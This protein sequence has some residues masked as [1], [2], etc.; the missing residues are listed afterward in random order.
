ME[1]QTARYSASQRIPRRFV[2][3]SLFT[4]IIG[5]CVT[6][7]ADPVSEMASFSVFDKVDLA[8]LASGGVKTAHGAPMSNARFLSVQTCYVSPGSPAQQI[9]A[10][11]QWNPTRHSELNVVLHSDIPSAATAVSFSR[12]R[13]APDSS[14]ARTLAAATEKRTELQISAEEA[15]KIPPA[16]GP[17]TLPASLAGFWIDLLA[18]RARTFA[19]GGSAAEPPY[20]LGGQSVRASQ[21][22]NGLLGQ[23]EKI[24]RQ[25]SGFIESAGIG[26]GAG[27][28]H[29]ELYWE[30][31]QVEDQGVLTLGA[32]QSRPGAGGTFQAAD[33]LYYASGG[34]Y[35]GLTL[36]QMWPVDVGGKPSTLVW[37]GDMISSGS[38]ESLHGIERL[39]SESSMMKDISKAVTLFRRDTGGSR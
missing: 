32:F 33:T 6:V 13:N 11:R 21:E 5:I 24:R 10:M 14:A 19:T 3:T 8:Q 1:T 29:P 31:L 36:Y 25:F 15:K 12:L 27:S 26:R 9:A 37:R 35:A 7:H 16:S 18:A 17:G 39:A 30:L 23:Q 22:L 38:V 20:N 34:Y 2:L 4:L 28:I